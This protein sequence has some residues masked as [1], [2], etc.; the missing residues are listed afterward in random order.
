MKKRCP[1]LAGL[2]L[3]A[4]QPAL[5]QTELGITSHW[6]NR[7]NYN[8]ATIAR[9]GFVYVFSNYRQQWTGIEGAPTMYNLNASGY[10]EKYRSAFG[11]SVLC[12]D[13]GVTTAL[14]PVFQYAYLLNLNRELKLSMGLSVGLYN[15][16]I[17]GSK[18]EAVIIDDPSIDYTTQGYSAPDAG[19]GFELQADH[20]IAGIASTHLFALWKPDNELLISNHRY[21]YALYKDSEHEAYNLTAGLQVS[22]R[23]NLTVLE[24]TGIVRFKH[25]TGLVKGPRELFDLGL[26]YR[27]SKQLTVLCGLNLSPHIRLGYTYDFN[28]NTDLRDYPSHEIL[29]EF[30]I[31]LSRYWNTGHLWYY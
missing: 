17:N 21:A 20:F 8:P 18:Y 9:P 28:F 23:S 6:Y 5:A 7:A 11:I 1:L 31:P 13:V 2:L 26:S 24:A 29:L 3:M 15:R 27:T 12:E 4:L 14:N 19:L 16:T 25:P 30:R 22:N 10:S